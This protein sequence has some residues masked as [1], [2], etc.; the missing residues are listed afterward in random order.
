MIHSEW[1]LRFS[2][3]KSSPNFLDLMLN[4]V[5]DEPKENNKKDSGTCNNHG[6]EHY[7]E[8]ARNFCRLIEE[9]AKES[10]WERKNTFH[11]ECF[12]E[13]FV[14]FGSTSLIYF[15]VK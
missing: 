4:N 2:K 3:K 14:E 7:T 6:K 12:E 13:I 9:D 11:S 10:R 5:E 8:V 1:T 15:Y